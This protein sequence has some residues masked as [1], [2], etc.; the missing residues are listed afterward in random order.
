M[1]SLGRR[2]RNALTTVRPP[3]PES[4]TPMGFD[5]SAEPPC[6]FSLLTGVDRDGGWMKRVRFDG[7][8]RAERFGDGMRMR[9][10]ICFCDGEIRHARAI[11]Y[12][13]I[14]ILNAL[15][16]CGPELQPVVTARDT[17]SF[18]WIADESSFEQ[19]RRDLDIPQHVKT[20]VPHTPIEG[21]NTRQNRG[22]DRSSQRDVLAIQRI[23]GVPFLAGAR[24]VVFA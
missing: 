20:R 6:A 23:A 3:M 4:K 14:V 22:V 21:R 9:R 5:F 24:G 19:D 12:R 7:L 1:D 16:N 13:G 17:L 18:R 8:V 2:V 15:G 11:I 10:Q